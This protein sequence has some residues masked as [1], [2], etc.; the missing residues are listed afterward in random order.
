MTSQL[1]T[2]YALG[3]LTLLRCRDVDAGSPATGVSRGFSAC[4]LPEDQTSKW[5][6][7]SLRSPIFQPESRTL[8]PS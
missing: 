3:G 8:P 6:C 1:F 5:K 4:A 2:P 7:A